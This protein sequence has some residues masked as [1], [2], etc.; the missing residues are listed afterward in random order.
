MGPCATSVVQHR[1]SAFPGSM[2]RIIRF[3]TNGGT[4][5]AFGAEPE[6][7][8]TEADVLEVT[9]GIDP[10]TG[11]YKQLMPEDFKPS[12]KKAKIEKLLAPVAPSNLFC[13][14]LNYKEHATE[15]QMPFPPRP[16]V[17]MK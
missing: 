14:G 13:I 3:L 9:S 17:F 11:L 2:P 10:A 15:S 8:A 16:V 5:V 6:P 1:A 4:E 12:G 7:G